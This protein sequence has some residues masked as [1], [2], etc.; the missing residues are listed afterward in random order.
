MSGHTRYDKIG[1]ECIKE[2]VGIASIEKRM[3]E[4]HPRWFS[5]MRR[6]LVEALIR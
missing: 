4:S 1:N 2:K 5:N 6:R 3:V